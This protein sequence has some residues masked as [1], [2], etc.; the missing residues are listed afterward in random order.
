MNRRIA[1]VAALALALGAGGALA[2]RDVLDSPPKSVRQADPFG[3]PVTCTRDE[4]TCWQAGREVAAPVPGRVC[5][6]PDGTWTRVGVS[7]DAGLVYSTFICNAP[8]LGVE[9]DNG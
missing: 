9:Q 3:Y 6:E 1:L 8:N 5:L 4:T 2:A 7:P